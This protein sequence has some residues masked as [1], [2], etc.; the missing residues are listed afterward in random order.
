MVSRGFQELRRVLTLTAMLLC[1][2]F[3]LAS[4]VSA[5]EAAD[6]SAAESRASSFR[7]VEGAD[8]EQVP[9]GNLMIGAYA[10]MW[11][12]VF[13]YVLRLQKIHGQTQAD[14]SRIERALAGSDE[15]GAEA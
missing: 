2:A 11:I 12:F 15:D 14:L 7:A 9:G 13:G 1:L 10:V 4:G 5:Q 3:P 6:D 8:A